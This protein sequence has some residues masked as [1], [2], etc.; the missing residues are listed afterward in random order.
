AI[1]SLDNIERIE[2]IKG[3]AARVFG[4]N[5]FT[6]AIN[7]ITKKHAEN[8]IRPV[9]SY[10][11]YNSFK[12]GL[13]FGLN[14]KN[15]GLQVHAQRQSSDGYRENSDYRNHALFLKYNQKN[16][17]FLAIYNSRRFGAENFYTSNPLFKEYEE[18][19]TSLM[20]FTL[21]E[22]LKNFQIT[23]RISWR[24][25][26]DMF[27]LIR[28]DPSF[29]RNLH[30]SNKL[31]AEVNTVL[32][33]KIGKTGFG[34]DL[35]KVFLVSNRLG[36][37]ERLMFTSFLEHRFQVGD[38]D[39]TPGIAISYFSDFGTRAFPGLDMGYAL[40]DK[41]KLYGNIGYT[42]RIPT[43]TD[44]YY[45]DPT[46][47][48]NPDLKPESALS[49]ELGLRLILPQVDFNL[50]IFNRNSDD[51]IDWARDS[52]QD[53]WQ[54]RNFSKVA[55]KGL[56]TT[57]NYRFKINNRDQQVNVS[58]TYIDDHILDASVAFTRYSLNSL[59]HQF[60]LSLNNGFNSFLS[61]SIDF[62]YVERTDGQ[63]YNLVNWKLQATGKKYR[64]FALVNNIFDTRYTG[65]NLVPMPG[66]NVLFG[67]DYKFDY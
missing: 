62:R 33:S 12:G 42:Y 4:Q 3:P 35:T 19:Q 36:D 14:T 26:Q 5:A 43:Y 25:N 63:H 37:H 28:D 60:I 38:F 49:E 10:G 56:E 29:Y 6:G 17:E 44:L 1:L 52:E 55:T 21:R 9:L 65:A 22:E 58:Y 23:P 30:I 39:A 57:T 51:L 2:I 47:E 59:K 41:L 64:A 32:S 18:T 7:I 16:T 40:S 20:A 54:A 34:V 27:L 24:R 67:L 8:G 15:G 53:K 11:S 31:S 13:G 45:S 66:T 48:G 46:S 61:Q 50:A